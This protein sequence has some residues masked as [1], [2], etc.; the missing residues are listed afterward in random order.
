MENKLHTQEELTNQNR[1][2]LFNQI[3]ENLNYIYIVIMIL[4]NCLISLIRIDETGT[5]ELKYPHTPAGWILWLAQILL[6]TMVGVMILNAFRRQGIK[7]GHKSIKKTYDEYISLLA[8][9]DKD[10]N[11]RSLREYMSTKALKDSIFKGALL[12]VINIMAIS[13]SIYANLNGLFAL[14]INVIFSVAFGIKE[15]LEA[16]DYVIT[17]L[18][19]WY[20]IKIKQL[21][22]RKEK[23]DGKLQKGNE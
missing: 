11:P 15:L 13:A 5:I 16:E 21:K 20:R 17:E 1:D 7:L 22:S 9:Q 2:K 10:M 23:K 3:K 4:A 14:V 18:V 6:I 8:M 12:V 19:I